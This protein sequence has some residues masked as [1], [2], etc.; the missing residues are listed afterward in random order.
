MAALDGK[1]VHG[2]DPQRVRASVFDL[3]GVFLAGGVEA[4]AAF[5]ERHGLD[6]GAWKA[7]RTE[8]FAND[9]LWSEVECGR[10]T[11]EDFAVCLRNRILSAGGS[12]GLEE[13]RNFMRTSEVGYPERLRPEII[14]AAQ[15]IHTRMPTA[16]LT[17]NVAEWRGAWRQTVEVETIFDVVIDSSEVG[18]RKPD[19]RIYEVTQEQ[20][21]VPHEEL[22]FVDDIGQNLKAARAL[23]WQ[24]LKYENTRSVLQVL[25]ALSDG[26][27]LR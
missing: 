18:L 13:A 17:N 19:V 9:G 22:F 1:L 5:G 7:I 25:D 2:I 12:V 23:G 11:L 24:T 15:R 4:V 27:P 3:G 20:L 6:A 16:L 26:P 10:C 8:I 21:G 14:A